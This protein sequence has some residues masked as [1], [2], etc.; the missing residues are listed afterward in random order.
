MKL[1]RSFIGCFL[2]SIPCFTAHGQMETAM[3]TV[4]RN[5]TSLVAIRTVTT[6][7][8][9]Q[10]NNHTIVGTYTTQGSGVIIDS[11]GLIVTNTHI[12]A[13]A[14]HIY[15]ALSD[16]TILEAKIVY[17][18]DAD[19][20]FIKIDPPYSL[21]TITWADSALAQ[22]GTPIIAISNNG[23]DEQHV[24]GGAVTDLMDGATSNNVEM[25][26]LNLTLYHGDSGGPLLDNDGHLLGLIMGKKNSEDA[27]TYAIASNKIAQEYEQYRNN[28][29]N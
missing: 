14:Q 12:V 6:K 5:Q 9:D 26:E 23:G 29:Q 20:S 17:S 25:F 18:S 24:L 19:F 11:T 2:I 3:Q 21:N 16:G 13:G 7:T 22:I 8:I 15:V 28:P 4:E 27:K 10:G 1:L